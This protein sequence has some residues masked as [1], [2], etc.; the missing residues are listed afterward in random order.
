MKQEELH[1]SNKL[2]SFFALLTS[3]NVK[4]FSQ[5]ALGSTDIFG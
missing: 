4:P 1:N 2:F 3:I 5:I